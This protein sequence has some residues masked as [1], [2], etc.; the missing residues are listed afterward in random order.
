MEFTHN[1]LFGL[2]PPITAPNQADEPA[3][4]EWF[5]LRARFAAAHAIR[6]EMQR[7]AAAAQPRTGGF[8]KW[9]A[10]PPGETF[11]V[12]NPVSSADGKDA[13]GNDLCIAGDAHASDRGMQ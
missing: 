13:A 1:T 6:C 7:L 8:G 2:K 12:V 11:T 5:G 4:P 10:N 9:A 3:M